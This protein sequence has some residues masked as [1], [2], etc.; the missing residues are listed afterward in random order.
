MKTS[1]GDDGFGYV[2][3]GYAPLRA[4]IAAYWADLVAVANLAT[5]PGDYIGQ[6]VE[7]GDWVAVTRIEFRI[8]P[9]TVVARPTQI[10]LPG[11]ST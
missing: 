6:F 5:N 8:V 3:P 4:K 10:A 1:V 2:F 9:G 7:S 11:V